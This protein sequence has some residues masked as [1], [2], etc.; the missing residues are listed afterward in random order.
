MWRGMHHLNEQSLYLSNV[1]HM[2]TMF[3]CFDQSL[4]HFVIDVMHGSNNELNDLF[5]YWMMSRCNIEPHTNLR[6]VTMWSNM[7]SQSIVWAVESASQSDHHH[8]IKQHS[9]YHSDLIRIIHQ[10]S[11]K[12]WNESNTLYMYRFLSAVQYAHLCLS[13]F[14]I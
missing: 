5:V 3:D 8:L 13:A 9:V 4:T 1:N 7:W 2:W 11:I 12:Q 14:T 10:D 6:N